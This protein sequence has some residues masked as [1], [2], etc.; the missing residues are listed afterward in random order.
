MENSRSRDFARD[1]QLDTR[2]PETAPVIRRISDSLR[3]AAQLVIQIFDIQV[4]NGSAQRLSC[5]RSVV[6][7]FQKTA[8]GGVKLRPL[9]QARS[10]G[11]AGLGK[12]GPVS[13]HVARNLAVR[14]YEGTA[15]ETT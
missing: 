2:K 15:Q 3:L 14:L 12:V 10:V 8:R 5:D 9:R 4:A 13:L 6:G 1:D 7:E 11:I